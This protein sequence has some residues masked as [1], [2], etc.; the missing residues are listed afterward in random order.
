MMQ[1]NSLLNNKIFMSKFGVINQF[2][3][4]ARGKNLGD[5]V[6][7]IA[8]LQYFPKDS[9]VFVDR[10]KL[11]EYKGEQ[12]KLIMNSWFNKYPNHWPPSSDIYP[13]FV[14]SHFNDRMIPVL[15]S[16]SGKNYLKKYEPIGC[17]DKETAELLSANGIQ[18][19]FSGC[20]TLTL[21]KTY[22]NKGDGAEILFVDVMY[23]YRTF[24]E[25]IFDITHAPGV[26]KSRILAGGFKEI[27]KMFRD[28]QK[29]KIFYKRIFSK[30]MLEKSNSYSQIQ[31][32]NNNQDHLKITDEYLKRLA[33]AKLVITSR[34]H[35]A[36][37]CLAMN[38]PVIFVDSEL[39]QHRLSG[40]KQLFNTIEINHEG[41][42]K[43]NFGFKGLLTSDVNVH[44]RLDYMS[45]KTHLEKVCE[46]FIKE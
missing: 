30:E 39:D 28:T 7:T 17:R 31:P 35:C 1:L 23:N 44:N 13:L 11:D 2:A 21:G 12:L 3:T 34:I 43:S 26:I 15:I 20:L 10:E 19:Y 33:S 9:A 25:L 18:A 36:L 29:K 24:K 14:S 41:N 16:D 37:P 42:V 40:L 6:Q 46:D 38:T 32:L 45:L 5:Y 22:Q 4:P 27:K 8:T